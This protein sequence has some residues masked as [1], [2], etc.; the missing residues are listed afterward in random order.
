M[1]THPIH[2]L[3]SRLAARAGTRQLE[4]LAH[5]DGVAD[6]AD[7]LVATAW[8][9]FLDLAR[10]G[11]GPRRLAGVFGP[12]RHALADLLHDRLSGLAEWAHGTAADALAQTLPVPYLA[13]AVSMEGNHARV[14]RPGLQRARGVHPQNP[15]HGP[16]RGGRPAPRPPLVRLAQPDRS[17]GGPY[18]LAEDT[19]QPIAPGLVQ[20]GFDD[21]G[22]LTA[23]NVAQPLDGLPE[24]EQRDYFA[25]LLFPPLDGPRL[26]AIL[27]GDDAAGDWTERLAKL[28]RLLDPAVLAPLLEQGFAAGDTL[29]QLAERIR[30]HVGGAKSDA[31]R[32][33]R[34]E[35]M[36]IAHAAQMDAHAGIDDLTIG[37]QVHA[38][39]DQNT[40]PH[41]RH[42]NGT[43]YYRQPTGGQ[44][45]MDRMPH[46][47]IEEDGS[48]AYNC[49]CWVSPVLAPLD[50]PDVVAVLSAGAAQAV[51]D[52]SVFSQWFDRAPVHLQRR[53]MG[54]RRL[55]TVRQLVD[56]P[57]YAHFV[58]PETGELLT[59]EELRAETHAERAVR[60]AHVNRLIAQR[61][62]DLAAVYTYGFLP[63]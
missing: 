59:A 60:V 24:A 25:A 9:R 30:P 19:A 50:H 18:P 2:A 39:L 8:Q 7:A 56:R 62:A 40:R 52:V 11:Q 15:D 61:Q 37:W 51:P 27:Y 63:A 43:V 21:A 58:R 16:H 22:S 57:T 49:R 48:I 23:T 20:F 41:H 28:T 10:A 35:G 12:V 29:D 32:I 46:P 47:P 4:L 54:A 42:R 31:R 33:A 13:A 17:A 3:N 34:T 26:A 5:C 53:A 38:L 44:L 14:H 36:R 45:G 55:A 1:P 6:A